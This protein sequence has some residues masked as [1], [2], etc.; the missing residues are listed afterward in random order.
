MWIEELLIAK[1]RRHLPAP[2]G[3]T[4]RGPALNIVEGV[5]PELA[6]ALPAL[7]SF[8]E[9]GSEAE[10]VAEGVVE[11]EGS[12]LTMTASIENPTSRIQL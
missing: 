6:V 12:G 2:F 1:W 10:R 7:R 5:C 3:L 8:S 4:Q 9:G 11:R